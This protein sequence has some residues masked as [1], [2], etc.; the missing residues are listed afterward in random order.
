MATVLEYMRAAMS[1]AVLEPLEDE[2]KWHAHIPALP[3]LWATGA[4]EEEARNELFE[5]LDGWLHVNAF[6]GS[7][8]RLPRID[9][10]SFYD[11]PHKIE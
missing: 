1:H 4:I 7:K 9:G 8:E 11:P 3:G 10:L 6:H 2:N 5:A